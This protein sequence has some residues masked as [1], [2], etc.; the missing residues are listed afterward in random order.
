MQV[1]LSSSFYQPWLFLGALALTDFQFPDLGVE[2]RRQ[3]YK[4]DRGVLL[5]PLIAVTDMV[6]SFSCGSRPRWTFASVW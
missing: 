2:S 3:D 6:G 4:C 1:L 5:V